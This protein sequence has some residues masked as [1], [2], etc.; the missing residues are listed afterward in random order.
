MSFHL[1][2]FFCR[3]FSAGIFSRMFSQPIKD[4]PCDFCGKLCTKKGV[5]IHKG[6]QHKKPSVINP[7]T[8]SQPAPDDLTLDHAPTLLEKLLSYRQ[9]ISVLRRIP[10]AARMSATST[11]TKVVQDCVVQMTLRLGLVSS[12]SPSHRC[13]SRKSRK[14]NF[15]WPPL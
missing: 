13:V 12:S 8:G 3:R 6:S 2:W 5:A 1:L 10:K 7:P 11:F 14:K 15:R 4:V 9:S